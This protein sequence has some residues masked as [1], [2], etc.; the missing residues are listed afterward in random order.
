MKTIFLYATILFVLPF[1]SYGKTHT[2]DE[3]VVYSHN[4]KLEQADATCSI[5]TNTLYSVALMYVNNRDDDYI[6]SEIM[7]TLD[8]TG[9]TDD[10]IDSYRQIVNTS[11]EIVA[12]AH[13]LN[14]TQAL[15]MAEH[16]HS[17]CV[18]NYM[19]SN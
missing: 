4:L 9:M 19:Q 1:A 7:F 17:Y 15:E 13:P 12:N 10:D 8:T 3:F 5:Y 6:R 16:Q 11:I 18:S 14:K 2:I